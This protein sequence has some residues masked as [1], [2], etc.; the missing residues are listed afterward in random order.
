MVN[1]VE[2]AD[3]PLELLFCCQGEHDW[4]AEWAMVIN[5]DN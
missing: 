4:I 3:D 2:R 1:D 5:C